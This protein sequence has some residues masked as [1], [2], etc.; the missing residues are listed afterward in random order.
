M[1]AGLSRDDLFVTNVYKKRTP[2][3]R[4]PMNSEVEEHLELLLH[5][6]EVVK[7]KVFLLLGSFAVHIFF[8]GKPGI[9]KIRGMVVDKPA[10][11]FVLTYH[12]SYVNRMKGVTREQ[13]QFDVNNFAELLNG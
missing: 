7:P 1:E 5:E 9:T 11:K 3:N 10:M 12:P 4:E 6:I 13:F 8:P 2:Q